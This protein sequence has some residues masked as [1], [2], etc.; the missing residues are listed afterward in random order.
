V[1]AARAR[2]GRVVCGGTAGEGPGHVVTPTL[3]DG[4]AATDDL[5][6]REVFGPLATVLP[7]A[8]FD[9]AV[10]I[11]NG[12]P[13]GLVTSVYTADLA[14]ALSLPARLR[15]GLVRI[16]A[17]STGVDLHAPFGGERGSGIGPREQGKAARDFYTT[18][19]TITVAP[20]L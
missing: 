11:A 2:G 8:S 3:L 19:R 14:L 7:A 4:L 1:S 18:P 9:D 6:Q 12:V 15:S 16:N 13:Q 5:N 20:P 10:E 17:P